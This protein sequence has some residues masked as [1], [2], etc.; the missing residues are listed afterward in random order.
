RLLCYI[1]MQADSRKFYKE[2]IK[3][4]FGWGEDKYT[5]SMKALKKGG[6]ILHYP[7]KDGIGKITNRVIELVYIE[8]PVGVISTGW[9]SQG[10]GEP[11]GGEPPQYNNTKKNNTNSNNNKEKIVS[12]DT[13]PNGDGDGSFSGDLVPI[14]VGSKEKEKSS[15]KKEK[16]ST[17]LST[18]VPK[19][20]TL[21]INKVIDTIKT[22]CMSCGII[23]SSY[24]TERMYAKHILSKKF[25]SEC[26]D[27]VNMQLYDFLENIVKLSSQVKYSK[28]LS[29]AKSVYYNRGDVINKAKQ[30]QQTLQSTQKR[31]FEY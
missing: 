29:S 30:Q 9:V 18:Y 23:Y 1:E 20:I 24:T 12:N 15:A 13:T 7:V 6:Y 28:M 25:K 10:V 19:E 22:A 5:L 17:E 4:R 14:N 21:E 26:L 2:E 27:Q 31:V 16:E 3:K 11:G 8:K